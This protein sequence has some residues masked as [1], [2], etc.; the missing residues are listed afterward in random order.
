MKK[1]S[2]CIFLV[3]MWCNIGFAETWSCIYEFN[4]ESRQNIIERKKNKFY[5]IY[6]DGVIDTEGMT[7]VKENKNFIHL[8]QHIGYP[9]D[10]TTAFVILLDKTK[11]SFVMVALEYQNSSDIIEGNCRIF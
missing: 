1:L 7:I 5:S 10:D 2:L 9:K 11:K 4:N 8:H 6:E 3:L